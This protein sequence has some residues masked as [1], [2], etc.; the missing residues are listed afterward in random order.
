MVEAIAA[1]C[2]EFES[3]GYQ[4]VGAALRQAGMV[5][6]HK[7]RRLMREHDSP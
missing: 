4:R 6:N 2:D 7:I 5:V 1:I 3:Y